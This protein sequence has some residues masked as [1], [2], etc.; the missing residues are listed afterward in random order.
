M[1]LLEYILKYIAE[2]LRVRQQ[3]KTRSLELERTLR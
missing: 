2:P 3:A 1:F